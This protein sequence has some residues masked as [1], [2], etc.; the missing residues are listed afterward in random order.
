MVLIISMAVW[1]FAS[2]EHGELCVVMA[3]MKEML[4]LYAGSLDL[5]QKVKM[6]I[7]H[8][9]FGFIIV[10]LVAKVLKAVETS[11][12]V[13]IFAGQVNCQGSE[14]QLVLCDIAQPNG[15]CNYAHVGCT[16]IESM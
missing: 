15:Q 8:G 7:L 12:T 13:P 9:I 1:R 16:R 14:E 3:G 10:P 6:C 4:K 11:E 2:T 5:I